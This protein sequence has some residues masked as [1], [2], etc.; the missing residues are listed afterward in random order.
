M[1]AVSGPGAAGSSS[2]EFVSLYTAQFLTFAKRHNFDVPDAMLGRLL[3]YVKGAASRDP[4]SSDDSNPAYAAYLLTANGEITTN[5]LLKLENYYKSASKDWKNSLSAAYIAAGYRLLQ[6]KS[7][8]DS[9]I[10]GYKT[11]RSQ[12]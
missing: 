6:D 12:D 9:L 5:Y 7:R 8:A 3:G 2:D 11:G 4:Q 1:T 10:N